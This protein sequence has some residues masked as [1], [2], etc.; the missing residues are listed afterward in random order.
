MRYALNNT[1]SYIVGFG[2]VNEE[3][4]YKI[5]E[6]PRAKEIETIYNFCLNSM[7]KEAINFPIILF[8]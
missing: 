5:V 6:L 8:V 3:N 1:Q 4:V 2:G 7:F